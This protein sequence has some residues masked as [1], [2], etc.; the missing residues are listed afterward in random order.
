MSFVA[1]N[2]LRKLFW[3][4]G[5]SILNSRLGFYCLNSIIYVKYFKWVLLKVNISEIYVIA[6]YMLS[7]LLL[8]LKI[9]EIYFKWVLSIV[10]ISEI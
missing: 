5:I 1:N 2:E 10:Y 4:L 9:Y 8:I 7:R 6:S 3:E